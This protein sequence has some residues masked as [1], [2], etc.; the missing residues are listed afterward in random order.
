MPASH[1]LNREYV[2][3]GIM[4]FK[5]HEIGYAAGV[6]S[7]AMVGYMQTMTPD[8]ILA[9]VNTH[10]NGRGVSSI[11]AS[12]NGWTSRGVT[13]LGE[14]QFERAHNPSPFK[15]HHLWI[16]LIHKTFVNT[17]ARKPRKPKPRKTKTTKARAQKGKVGDAQPKEARAT[18]KAAPQKSPPPQT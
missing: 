10:A 8:E 7:A 3:N 6:S 12:S 4:R 5:D 18:K 9:Q 2:L 17:P 1:V 13:T 16:D 14:H 11:T 15:L